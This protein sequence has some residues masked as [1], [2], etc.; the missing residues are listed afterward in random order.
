LRNIIQQVLEVG[1][2]SVYESGAR[3][4]L[5]IASR[6]TYPIRSAAEPQTAGVNGPVGFSADRLI[7]HRIM[8]RTGRRD[9]YFENMTLNSA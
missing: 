4:R 2:V 6:H 3:C 7:L 1:N 8:A 5:T 9:N